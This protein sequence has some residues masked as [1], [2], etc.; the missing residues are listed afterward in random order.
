MNQ[1]VTDYV[2]S[3]LANGVPIATI[4]ANLLAAGWQKIQVET[5]ILEAVSPTS[6]STMVLGSE[7]QT[8]NHFHISSSLLLR[9]GLAF[10][11]TYAATE[12]ALDPAAGMHYIP[13]FI[14]SAVPPLI[15]LRTL[16]IYEV[17]LS[18]WLLSGKLHKYA[19]I[20]AAVTL[21]GITSLNLA[22][23]NVLFRNVAI[24]FA[25]LA[26]AAL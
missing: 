17:I 25:G 26:L 21:F 20:L 22:S 18:F 6:S 1:Q 19:G 8:Q 9:I 7:K 4:K 11:F 5:F 24:I 10:V 23:L 15:L 16:E 2:K 12:F 14:S 13:P 3:N